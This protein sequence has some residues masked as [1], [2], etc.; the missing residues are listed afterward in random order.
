M[1]WVSLRRFGPGRDR[2]E[3][4]RGTGL[5]RPGAISYVRTRPR[6]YDFT[7]RPFATARSPGRRNGDPCSDRSLLAG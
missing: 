3:C 6:S 4:R 7:G 5:N 1:P 2:G